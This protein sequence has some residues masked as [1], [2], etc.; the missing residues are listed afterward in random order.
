MT[1]WLAAA[2]YTVTL[3]VLGLAFA[4][5]RDPRLRGR[6]EARERLTGARMLER[7][8]GRIGF[9]R[10]RA[11]LLERLPGVDAAHVD[12]L[13]AS[14][15]LLSGAGLLIGAA[16]IGDGPVVAGAAGAALAAGA[17]RLPDFVLARSRERRRRVLDE[18]VS[19]LLDLVAVGVTA[20]LTPRLALERASVTIRDPLRRELAA[21]RH[22]VS[23]GTPWPRAL[24]EAARSGGLPTL[25]RLGRTL[26]R[27]ERFGAPA[28]PA[29]RRLA[30]DVRA[31]RRA[32]AEER[33]RR[34]PVVLLFPL[35][36]LILPA[37]VLAAVVPAVLVAIR[38]VT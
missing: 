6:L 31:D 7:L 28:A 16:A 27:S 26:S 5:R 23:L 22:R 13:V 10:A 33:A 29:V 19:E 12:R 30:S 35:V 8:G 36:F 20:G 1:A 37:F 18:V 11:R 21:I 2:G 24:E 17:Y 4:L 34:A 3:V 14:K 32:R 25:G 38:G 9:P 15:L